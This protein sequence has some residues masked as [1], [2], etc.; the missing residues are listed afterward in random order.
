MQKW[1]ESTFSRLD[2]RL[3]SSRSFFFGKKQGD[4]R[5]WLSH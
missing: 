2:E 4:Q 1:R 3:T 5:L